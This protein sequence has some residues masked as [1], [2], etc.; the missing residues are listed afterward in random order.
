M[1]DAQERHAEPAPANPFW[2]GTVGYAGLAIVGWLMVGLARLL[3][4]IST[5]RNIRAAA[6]QGDLVLAQQG[7]AFA[8]G[9]AVDM[10]FAF[11]TA[12]ILSYAAVAISRRT[13]NAW[14]H[15]TL[16]VGA[17]TVFSAIMLCAR[18]RIMFFIPLS[19]APLLV[20]LY[21]PGTKAACGVRPAAAAEPEPPADE[22][23]T[24]L[25]RREIE[26]EIARERALITQLSQNLDVFEVERALP[27]ERFVARYAQGLEEDSADNAEWFSIA[28]A[29]GRSRERLDALRAQLGAVHGDG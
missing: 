16:A 17:L 13:W 15:A 4:L 28:R 2:W 21:L 14:D 3:Y 11:G 27:T 12:A 7:S 23:V 1:A 22:P 18:G 8:G 10:L 19:A 20:L 9:L 24:V 5:Q 6:A 26:A 25:T 29:V